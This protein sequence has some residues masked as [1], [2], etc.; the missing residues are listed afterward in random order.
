MTKNQPKNEKVLDLSDN[1]IGDASGALDG[2]RPVA[3][4]RALHLDGNAIETLEGDAVFPSLAS[5]QRLSLSR[6]GLR[7]AAGRA[8]ADLASLEHLDLS[9]NRLTAV[10]DDVWVGASAL[11][12][13]DLAGNP[14]GDVRRADPLLGAHPRLEHLDLSRCSIANISFH[15][16]QVG[17]WRLVPNDTSTDMKKSSRNEKPSNVPPGGAAV[18]AAAPPGGQRP[19]VAG[20]PGPGAFSPAVRAG[21]VG[22]P[23]DPS[24]AQS[25]VRRSA[26]RIRSRRCLRRWLARR[27]IARPAGPRPVRQSAR[28]LRRGPFGSVSIVCFLFPAHFLFASR[29]NEFYG[30]YHWFFF[31]ITGPLPSLHFFNA[32]GCGLVDV[33][34]AAWRAVDR[35]RTLDLSRNEL[36]HWNTGLC[37]VLTRLEHLDLRSNKIGRVGTAPSCRRLVRLDLSD[38]RLETLPADTFDAFDRL[39]HLELNGNRLA[40]VPR[41]DRCGHL[42]SVSL[43][44]NRLAVVDESELLGGRRWQRVDLSRNRLEQLPDD[45]LAWASG[46]DRLAEIDLSFNA[47]RTFSVDLVRSLTGLTKLDLSFNQIAELE[48]ASSPLFSPPESLRHLNLSHNNISYLDTDAIDVNDIQVLDLSHNAIDDLSSFNISRWLPEG[49]RERERESLVGCWS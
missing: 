26:G 3:S 21:P 10:A 39:E 46:G 6:N 13:L 29:M 38:N 34:W 18:A 17:T 41:L 7:R 36:R 37:Q 27:R 49:E 45:F 33:D 47:L 35:L 24:V 9:D 12:R 19:A 31:Q 48:L 42:R 16:F 20:Q 22:Q 1:R 8:L 23:V 28:T 40:K 30:W 43:S 5:L 14:L 32:S 44:G 4:L 25:A 2:V 11:R 15:S